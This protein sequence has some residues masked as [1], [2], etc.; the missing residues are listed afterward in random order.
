MTPIPGAALLFDSSVE[1]A[2]ARVREGLDRRAQDMAR[3]V[4]DLTGLIYR[5]GK[6]LRARFCVMLGAALDVPERGDGPGAVYS[7]TVSEPWQRPL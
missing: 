1:A 3:R 2:L 4:G 6:L 5:P 7:S